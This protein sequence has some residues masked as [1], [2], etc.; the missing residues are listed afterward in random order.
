MVSL[1]ATLK[2]VP[3]AFIEPFGHVRFGFKPFACRWPDSGSSTGSCSKEEG[4][5]ELS[6]HDP[7]RCEEV[8][9]RTQEGLGHDH[10]RRGMRSSEKQQR[11]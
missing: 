4:G 6:L 1:Y 11:G 3:F 7:R 10:F 2:R 9:D 5:G 8:G